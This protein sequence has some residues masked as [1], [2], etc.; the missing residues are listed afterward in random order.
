MGRR[1]RDDRVELAIIVDGGRLEPTRHSDPAHGGSAPR[2]ARRPEVQVLAL[3]GVVALAFATAI[4]IAADSDE[5]EG[6]PTTTA[7]PAL[8]PIDAPDTEVPARTW[9]TQTAVGAID[10]IRHDGG[11]ELPARVGVDAEGVLVGM[12]DELGAMRPVDEASGWLPA[13]T[14]ERVVSGDR[15]GQHGM[16]D[17]LGLGIVTPIGRKTIDLTDLVEP[18][19]KGFVATIEPVIG[20]ADGFPI[21]LDGDVFLLA[22]TRVGLPWDEIAN[23]GPDGAYRVELSDRDRSFRFVRGRF[24]E[25][26][27]EEF[28]L[29]PGAVGTHDVL[30][31]GGD[32][33]WSFDVEPG[34]SA[35][36][37]A[38][39][40]FETTWLRWNGSRFVAIERPWPDWHD[41]D[42]VTVDGGVLAQSVGPLGEDVGLWFSSDGYSWVRGELPAERIERTPVA[43]T[44][45]IGGA[46]LTVV[47]EGGFQSWATRDG[48][49]FDRL[50]DVPGVTERRRGD[51]GWI[52][53]D[54]RSAPTLRLS[55]DGASWE[56]LDLGPLLDIDASSWDVTITAAV[57]GDRIIVVADRSDDRSVLVGD[58]VP[59]GSG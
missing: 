53:A 31:A 38:A 40:R 13:E 1:A 25:L 44:R 35:L 41:V 3:S 48:S 46:I 9:R 49:G 32:R 50:P 11:S 8:A 56:E 20:L 10:W 5:P 12:D 14:I 15:W 17:S 51:F 55:A 2:P 6:V 24:N 42:M 28:R 22:S 29:A 43:L 52:A 19:P 37:A 16:G 39:G 7:A 26:S 47:A 21:E 30:D 33:V 36:E 27:I 34:R 45:D 4:V 18:L 59:D 58:V 23:P 57:D 54:P